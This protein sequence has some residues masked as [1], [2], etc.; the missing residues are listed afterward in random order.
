M[1]AVVID[2]EFV[3]DFLNG[4]FY[5]FTQIDQFVLIFEQAH[6]VSLISQLVVSSDSALAYLQLK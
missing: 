3:D 6:L 1:R 2:V 5:D 4:R